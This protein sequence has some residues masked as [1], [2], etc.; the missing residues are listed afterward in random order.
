MELM[1]SEISALVSTDYTSFSTLGLILTFVIGIIFIV[2]SYFLEQIL[3]WVQRRWRWDNYAL[4]EWS[5]NETLQ[6][7]SLAH[8]GFGAGTWIRK[9]GCVPTTVPKE[10]LATLDLSDPMHPL[11][12]AAPRSWE[13]SAEAESEGKKGASSSAD[14]ADTSSTAPSTTPG[15]DTMVS[16]AAPRSWDESAKAESEGKEGA[17]SSA[18]EADTSLLVPST[19][20]GRD[21]MVSAPAHNQTVAV[22]ILDHNRPPP[23]SDSAH[24][25]PF[26]EV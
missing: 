1:L 5:T 10:L 16:K 15:R 11:L 25:M 19:A 9:I 8:E 4:T 26:E 6:L 7:Q 12:K 18:D 2:I 21:T 24:F 13:E 14:E 23:A 3:H 20:P 17:S 22:E